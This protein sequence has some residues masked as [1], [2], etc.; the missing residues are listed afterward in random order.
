VARKADS[1]GRLLPL[2]EV[3]IVDD[4]DRPVAPGSFGQIRCR[5]ALMARP[6]AES[7]GDKRTEY[8]RNGWY[9]P[10]DVGALD[11]EGYLRL[12]GR[13]A[14]IIQRGPAT[15]FLPEI[16]AA[17]ATHPNVAEVAVIDAP[18]PRQGVEIVAFIV[19]H[20][21]LQHDELARH[22][23][24]RLAPAQRPD[25]VYYVDTLPRIAGGK[26]DRPRLQSLAQSEAV[27]QGGAG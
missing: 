5:G 26:L 25:R 17:L 27:R 20:G 13:T 6:C 16:E 12:R 21:G 7:A 19:A 8:F 24:D 23:R 18:S 1:V 3:E 15:V 10:G 9:Y 22:C 14:E 2:V 11:A 4:D